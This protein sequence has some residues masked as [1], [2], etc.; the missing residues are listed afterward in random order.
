MKTYEVMLET[1]LTALRARRVAIRRRFTAVPWP[2]PS[3]GDL[4]ALGST[5]LR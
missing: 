2:E 3:A 4:A 1:E 5:N